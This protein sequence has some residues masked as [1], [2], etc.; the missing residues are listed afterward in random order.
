MSLG[1]DEVAMT[2][3]LEEAAAQFCRIFDEL[4]ELS[5]ASSRRVTEQVNICVTAPALNACAP[6][7]NP[8]APSFVS[9]NSSGTRVLVNPLRRASSSIGIADYFQNIASFAIFECLLSRH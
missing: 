5:R 7:P 8:T 6:S 1:L 2:E 9:F 3:T 4:G